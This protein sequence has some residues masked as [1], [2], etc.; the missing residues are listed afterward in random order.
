[1]ASQ[2]GN[3]SDKTVL[4]T[5]ATDG[6]FANHRRSLDAYITEARR[7]MYSMREELEK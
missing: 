5:G 2:V 4:V 7:K 3:L 1:L 6:L